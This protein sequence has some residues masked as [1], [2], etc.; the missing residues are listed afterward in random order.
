[1]APITQRPIP[2]QRALSLMGFGYLFFL[3]ISF[4]G[5]GMKA[6][7]A[8][9]LKAYLEGDGAGLGEMGSFVIG[10]LGTALVQSS[11]TV[12][13]MAVVMTQEGVL[14]LII[15]VGIVHG[16][17]LGTS[18]TSSLV[19]FFANVK[20]STGRLWADLKALFFGPR[21]AGF[22]PAVGTAVVHDMFNIIMVTGILLA[23]ELPFGII[24]KSAQAS[25]ATV[26]E[27]LQ[28]IAWLPGVLKWVSPGA[29]TK[30]VAKALMEFGVPGWALAL[31]GLPLLFASLK[32]FAGRMKQAVLRGVDTTDLTAVGDKLLGKTGF[33]T[34]MRGLIVTILVQSSSATTSMVVPLAA[35][36]LFSV[37]KV[38]PF[39]LGA[40][41]GTTT[42]AVLAASA[43]VGVAGFEVG[44]TVALSHLYLNS[45]AVLIAVAIPGVTTSILGS[46]DWVARRAG[47][48]PVVLPIYLALL[49]LVVPAVA[50][51][52][53]TLVSAIVLGVL[54]LAMLGGPHVARLRGQH[55]ALVQHATTATLR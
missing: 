11:S 16:A 20:P 36:G 40:N 25:A 7:F 32:G 54:L 8:K 23:L 15:A 17:N 46:A 29:Y 49:A 44:M 19:A 28:S 42:T 1:M 41:I 9:P 55:S 52:L 50:L 21:E 37:R 38:F 53:P 5:T 30:P 10:I 6:S 18:V 51:T 35:M 45:L 3:A 4:V 31:A 2:M 47:Q 26:A 43:G 34:F 39:I 13:S 27:T 22:R 14:P 12:T 48:R 33:D 24:M